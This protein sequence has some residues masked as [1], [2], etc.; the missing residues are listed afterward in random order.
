[1]TEYYD[2][3]END[4]DDEE[5]DDDDD[6]D[7]DEEHDDEHDEHDEYDEHDEHDGLEYHNIVIYS[8]IVMG[9]LII[10]VT[11]S[12]WSGYP[13]L[14]QRGTQFCLGQHPF[15]DWMIQNMAIFTGLQ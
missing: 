2:H 1:M 14:K 5:D 13:V 4:D 11:C 7:A 10:S 6:A 9:F 3:D 15:W 12:M 8:H